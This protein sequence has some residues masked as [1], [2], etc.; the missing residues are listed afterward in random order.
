MTV[1]VTPGRAKETG[2]PPPRPTPPATGLRLSV[3]AGVRA[4]S[5]LSPPNTPSLPGNSKSDSANK[6]GGLVTAVA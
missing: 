5:S 2:T 3:R 6:Q 4:Q 1:V